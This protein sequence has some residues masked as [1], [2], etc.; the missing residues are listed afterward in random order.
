M[1][2]SASSTHKPALAL[3][4]TWQ[5]HLKIGLFGFGCVGQGLYDIFTKTDLSAEIVKICVKNPDKKRSLPATYFTF[6]AQ[7]L[8]ENTEINLIVELIN[9][10]EAAYQ[11][12]KSAMLAGKDVVTAN[13]KMLALHLPELIALQEQTG[14]ALL[15]EAAA[16]G[17]IPIIRNLAEYYDNELLYS[18][19]GIF[20]G[21]SNYILTKVMEEKLSYERALKEAQD[22][23]FAETDPTL[24]VAGF[25]AL[26]KLCLIATQAYGILI[27]PEGVFRYGISALAA[28]DMQFAKEK[29]LKIK[30]INYVGKVSEE[31][32]CIFVMPQF[33]DAKHYLYDVNYEY[34]GVIVEAA[35]S[36]KQLFVGKGAGGHP[37][38]SA[39]LSDISAC[40]YNY[41]YEYR[42]SRREKAL[43]VTHQVLLEV[44]VRYVHKSDLEVFDF[45]EIRER[46]EGR[47][48]G[49]VIGTVCLEDLIAKRERIESK[50]LFLAALGKKPEKAALLPKTTQ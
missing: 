15:Y 39:V 12:V 40:R 50:P 35:F 14:T 5:K 19:S 20:N 32:I 49:Y 46:Y 43:R 6:E 36:D 7:D 31:E 41:R 4:S 45:I 47:S 17:S 33:V 29:G 44:Y 1:N 25:D 30:L 11:I 22:L 26:Y 18:V 37:T 34:N 28:E 9:D 48:H 13:K 38:G 24:D 42:K 2:P 8:L 10:A 27:E 3:H 16:C 21:S 23:G